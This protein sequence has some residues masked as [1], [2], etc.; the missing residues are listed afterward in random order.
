M[1]AKDLAE[2]LMKTP[3][4]EVTVYGTETDIYYEIDETRIVTA[5]RAKGNEFGWQEGYLMGTDEVSEHEC[6]EEMK[7]VCLINI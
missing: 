7:V 6:S 4:F 2:K 1:K 3:D 5:R